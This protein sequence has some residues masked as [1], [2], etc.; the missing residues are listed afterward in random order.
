M[1]QISE[2]TKPSSSI[3]DRMR[4]AEFVPYLG[5]NEAGFK[6]DFPSI[7]NRARKILTTGWK[8]RWTKLVQRLEL[9]SAKIEWD[10][11]KS[12]LTIFTLNVVIEGSLIGFAVSALTGFPLT[13]VNVVGWG[14]L[15]HQVLSIHRRWHNDVPST[16]LPEKES[17]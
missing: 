17:K 3:H 7:F 5:Q 2:G 13:P 15:V 16:K 4:K 8:N 11:V 9:E 10:A 6:Y 14:V 12:D 1:S